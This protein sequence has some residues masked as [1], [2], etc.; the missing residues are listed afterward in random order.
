MRRVLAG[1]DEHPFAFLTVI[2]LATC[3]TC[4]PNLLDEATRH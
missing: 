4:A 3:I 2:W 1:C